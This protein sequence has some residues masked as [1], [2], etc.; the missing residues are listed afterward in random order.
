LLRN[1][2]ITVQAYVSQVGPLKLE[3]PYADLNLPQ[4]EDNA[5]R[6]PDPEMAAR[7]FDFIDQTRKK[8]DSVGGVVTAVVTGTPAGLG[9]PVFDKLN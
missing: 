2:G 3:T 1:L 7:M 9:E 8:G 5:V 4:A 6:C